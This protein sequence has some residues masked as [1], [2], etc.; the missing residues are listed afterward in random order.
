MRLFVSLLITVSLL[1]VA[2]PPPAVAQDRAP[3]RPASL[4]VN[5]QED[6]PDVNDFLVGPARFFLS[7]PP[8][9]EETVE[10]QITNREGSLAAYDLTTEDFAS[11]PDLE[12]LPMFFQSRD[13]GPY[14]AR[15]W[16]TP[17]ADRFELRHGERAFIR[18]TVRVPEH[19]E[20]GDHQAALI[21]TRD[22]ASQPV[23]GFTIVS[24]VAALFIITVEGDVVRDGSVDRLAPLRRIFW[25]LPATVRLTAE[26][27]G[28]V[29]MAPRGAIRIRNVFGIP[30][31]SLSVREWYILRESSRS[32]SFDWK[33]RFALGYYT[34]TTDLTVFGDQP[35][36]PLTASF[37][38]I[39]IVPVVLLLLLIFLV[40]LLVQLF[41][42]RFE[43][44]RK[45]P[46]STE[47][48]GD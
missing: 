1:S 47:S 32:R 44:R 23:S 46:D 3:Q 33:P 15:Q 19:A 21:F 39:P 36:P 4:R 34:A 10:I 2:V 14:P 13:E 40:S 45:Q 28:T 43:L 20:A 41:F 30:V 38:V 17:E 25:F 9:G 35:V 12:G 31:D 5:L 42:S 11:G 37:W 18:V 6:M 29:H 22:V 26:N 7:L 24:R 8:G 16:I 27:R 48:A